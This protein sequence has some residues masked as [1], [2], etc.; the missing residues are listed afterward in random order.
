MN[1]T[2]IALA[3]LGSSAAYFILGGLMFVMFP[4]LK[5]EVLKYPAIYRSE[6]GIKSKMPLAMASIFLEIVVLAVIY[7]MLYQGGSGVAEGARFGVLI[8]VFSVCSF[9]IH[10]YVNLNIGGKITIQQSVAYFAQWLTVGIV[11]GLIYRPSAL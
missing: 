6:D 9:A 10:N 5:R 1:F 4:G 8:G 7:S 11:I 3:A 2:R